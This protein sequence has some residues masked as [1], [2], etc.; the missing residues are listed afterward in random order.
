MKPDY[1]AVLGV[2][3]DSSLSD[4]RKAYRRLALQH[5]PDKSKEPDAHERFILINEAYLIL[6][7]DEARHR[8]D[9]ERRNQP[10][11]YTDAG[12]RKSEERPENEF[13]YRTSA[14]AVFE[15][16]DLNSWVRN[17]RAQAKKFS[18]MSFSDFSKLMGEVGKET[19]TQGIAAIIYAFSGILG[20]SGLLSMCNGLQY[21]DFE[22]IAIATVMIVI[23]TLGLCFVSSKYNQ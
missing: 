16:D 15:S 9:A 4:I 7:D 10:A 14:G 22:Q 8:Y 2:H 13:R 23:S 19:A 1:Y 3:P 17:A 11:T 6:S 20:A 5:H 21:L 12:D 18:N